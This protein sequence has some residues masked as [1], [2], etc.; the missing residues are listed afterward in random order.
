MAAPRGNYNLIQALNNQA[1]VFKRVGLGTLLNNL[2]NAVNALSLQLDQAAA[3]AYGIAAVSSGSITVGGT[4]TAGN[5]YTM[6][7]IDA[8]VPSLVTPGVTL[9]GTVVAGDTVTTI[10]ARIAAAINA[11]LTLDTAGL[12]VASTAGVVTVKMPGAAGA[13]LVVTSSATGTLTLTAVSPT[14]GTGPIILQNAA[15]YTLPVLNTIP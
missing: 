2:V 6:T 12:L 3:L 11:N 7:F 9:T 8:G 14:G 1:P 10:A 15:A 13:T 5:T 4:I